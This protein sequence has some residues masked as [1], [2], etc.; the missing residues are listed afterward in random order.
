MTET[1]AL[2][3][4]LYP[5]ASQEALMLRKLGLLRDLWNAA[6]EQRILAWS[7]DKRAISLSEQEKEL[8]A[9]RTQVAD[10]S[11]LVHTHEAQI[12]L[13]RL[14]LAFDAFFR[15]VRAG[16]TP[17]FPRFKSLDRFPGWGY[18]E[19]GN[20]FRVET[21]VSMR[22]GR[23]RLSGVGTMRMRGQA[24]APGRILKADVRRTARGWHLTVVVETGCAERAPALDAAAGLDW[25]VETFATIAHEDGSFEAVPNPR[26][27]R[28]EAAALADAQRALSALARQRKISGRALRKARKA[29]ARRHAKVAAQRKDFLHKTSAALVR[30]FRVLGTE[31]LS[32]SNMTRSARGTADAPGTN[33]AQ[34]A[35][36]N[37]SIL[38]TAPAAFLN[39]LRYKAAEAGSEFLEANTRKLKPSQRCPDCDAVR[40]KAL[41]VRVHHCA[42]GCRLTRDEASSRVLLNWALARSA[43]RNPAG[44]VGADTALSG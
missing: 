38:D 6:L 27:L 41:D 3:Y 32:V 23:V 11:G 44:T 21:G 24:R 29:L 22:H 19:H 28:A 35:G 31:T 14:K 10:W 26:L 13:K 8:A 36:L 12:V 43:H 30:R 25:G 2:T 37:R 42:C 7:R 40:K 18:K 5:S 17:G 15:R 34:K 9:V 33:V 16:Q 39:M 20:G 4:K 1:R